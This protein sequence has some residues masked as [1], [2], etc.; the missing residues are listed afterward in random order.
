MIS[1]LHTQNI[2]LNNFEYINE[3]NN[4]YLLKVILS[5]LLTAINFV[6][7]NDTHSDVIAKKCLT[8]LVGNQAF[9]Y[10]ST[11][12]RHGVKSR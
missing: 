8:E 9:T 2:N 10:L 1:T 5:Y 12:D 7:E 3:V 11:A 6:F 4:K